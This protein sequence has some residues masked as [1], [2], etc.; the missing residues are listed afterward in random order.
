MLSGKL[1]KTNEAYAIAKILGLKMTEY[2]NKQYKTNY[3]SLQPTNLYG[4]NDNFDV[5]SGHVIPALI[6]KF[7]KAKIMKKKNVEIWGSGKVRR[8][9]LF[10]DDLADAIY[11]IISKNVKNKLINV[12]SG[13]EVTISNL[14]KIIKKTVDFKGKIY[15]NKTKPDGTPRKLV[16]N[17]IL[18]SYGWKSKTSLVKGLKIVYAQFNKDYK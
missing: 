12:G 5:N 10:V 6:N 16:S 7:H 3:I 8:E 18:K 4:L 13:Y 2:Y 9:F 11:F 1:E 17:K 14:A 15:F